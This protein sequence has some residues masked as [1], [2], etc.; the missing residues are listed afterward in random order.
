MN[1]VPTYKAIRQ[2]PAPIDQSEL[3]EDGSAGVPESDRQPVQGHMSGWANN[4]KLERSLP[5][6]NMA[7]MTFDATG[8]AGARADIDRFLV[9]LA[10]RCA[11]RSSPWIGRELK[12]RRLLGGT[13]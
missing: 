11:Y 8:S 12:N 13:G 2:R 6:G 7:D 3:S 1:I 9:T 5:A 10:F 4:K